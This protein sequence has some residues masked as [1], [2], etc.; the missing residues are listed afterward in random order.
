MSTRGIKIS[1]RVNYI[2]YDVS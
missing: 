2:Y 1:Y